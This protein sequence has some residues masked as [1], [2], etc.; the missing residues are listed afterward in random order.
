[1]RTQRAARAWVVC[2]ALALLACTIA[3]G[4]T[5]GVTP[6]CSDAAT[7]CGPSIDGA[8]DTSE[9]SLFPET[10]KPDTSVDAAGDAQSDADADLDAGDGG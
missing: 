4:C 1:M 5:D 8:A 7:Q 10:S 9:A 3:L 2:G 6:D